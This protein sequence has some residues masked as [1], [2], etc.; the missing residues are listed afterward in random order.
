MKNWTGVSLATVYAMGFGLMGSQERLAHS[1]GVSLLTLLSFR[2][3]ILLL[4]M[5]TKNSYRLDIKILTVLVLMGVF[6]YAAM[7]FFLFSSYQ[8]LPASIATIIFYTYPLL[9]YIF[10][11]LFKYEYI[12]PF[13]NEWIVDN[14][15]K[16]F[17]RS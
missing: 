9:T 6:G 2:F 14:I 17:A 8:H 11:I 3:L 13:F 4:G 16:R 15:F 7:A 12:A 5:F 1:N 10:S